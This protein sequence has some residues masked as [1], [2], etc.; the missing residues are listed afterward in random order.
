MLKKAK[1]HIVI[2]GLK[3]NGPFQNRD[4]IIF[5]GAETPRRNWTLMEI[6]ST[7]KWPRWFDGAL[8]SWVAVFRVAGSPTVPDELAVKKWLRAIGCEP[9]VGRAR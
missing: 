4:D 8:W 3:S 2:I 9:M 6:D 7:D 5:V 1:I